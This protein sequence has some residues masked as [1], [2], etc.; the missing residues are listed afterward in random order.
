MHSK[1]LLIL[2]LLVVAGGLLGNNG[3]G[4]ASAANTDHKVAAQQ[5]QRMAHAE[6]L[7]GAPEVVNF[8]EKRFLRDLYSLRDEVFA[9][10]TYIADINGG[11]HFI[12]PS[13]GFGIGA[14]TQFTNPTK[15]A[16]YLRQGGIEQLPQPEPNG[17]FVPEGLAA[18]YVLCTFEGKAGV[19]PFYSEPTLIVSPVPAKNIASD[20]GFDLGSATVTVDLPKEVQQKLERTPPAA[21][22]S[23]GT[24]AG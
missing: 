21:E 10:Y 18:T 2:A 5:E 24:P 14:S 19:I 1:I 7:V 22:T 4:T 23:A 8:T 11:L 20:Y 9:T 3:C 16:R 17:T 6:R 15:T 13:I 12:C